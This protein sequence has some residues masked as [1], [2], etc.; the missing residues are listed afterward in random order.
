MPI[1][2]TPEVDQVLLLKILETSNVSADT[3]AIAATWPEHMEKPTSR[4]IRERLVKIRA[5]AKNPNGTGSFTI[6]KTDK[7]GSS[8]AGTPA[9]TPRKRAANGN[10]NGVKKTTSPKK[11]GSKVN[12][13][14][15]G[16]RALV[17]NDDADDDSESGF[18]SDNNNSDVEESPSKK[19]KIKPDADAIIKVEDQGNDDTYYDSSVTL[20]GEDAVDMEDETYA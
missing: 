5:S 19:A 6:A 2:W 14:A 4:A 11:N 3:D 10:G 8:K 18:K 12:G 7:G 17:V 15:M 13:A 1:K 9:S 20:G 16:K